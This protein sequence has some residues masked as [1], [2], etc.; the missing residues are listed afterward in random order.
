MV[1]TLKVNTEATERDRLL[2]QYREYL[3]EQQIWEDQS[4]WWHSLF[5]LNYDGPMGDDLVWTN[6]VDQ[7]W[8]EQNVGL[9][10]PDCFRQFLRAGQWPQFLWEDP[11]LARIYDP[12]L[13]SNVGMFGRVLDSYTARHGFILYHGHNCSCIKKEFP[14]YEINLTL[15]FDDLLKFGVEVLE[16]RS[17]IKTKIAPSLTLLLN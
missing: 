6:D 17:R 15:D 13:H 11:D 16:Q 3:E 10:L 2:I 14:P 8:Q 12:F 5:E 1:T 9:V 4:I 7:F